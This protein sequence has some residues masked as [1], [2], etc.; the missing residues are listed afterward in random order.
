M[1]NQSPVHQELG[2]AHSVLVLAD[3]L[4][5]ARDAVCGSLLA[6]VPP[7][8]LHVLAVT[9]NRPAAEWLAHARSSVGGDPATV[10]VVDTGSSDG[11]DPRV[12]L[13][14]PDDL[15]GLEIAVC[16]PLP[17]GD[18]TTVFCF[19][20]LTALLQYV[21]RERAFRFL[22]ALVQRLWAAD[23]H[24]HFHMDPAAHAP[25]TV[26]MLA[27]LFDAVVATD[28]VPSPTGRDATTVVDGT[29]VSLSLRSRF[30]TEGNA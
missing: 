26:A 16:D 29:D 17:Y 25:D 24:A 27:S 12:V 28:R 21:D 9:Y 4:S 15:T 3:G 13:A 8:Q 22:H 23:A 2:D 11:A 30:G 6:R 7:A 5:E 10:R 20:S 18:D 14:S 1:T 19:D